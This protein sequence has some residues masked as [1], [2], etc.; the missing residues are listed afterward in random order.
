[1]FNPSIARTACGNE[2]LNGKGC[3]RIVPSTIC[4]KTPGSS[5][6][7]V[8]IMRKGQAP[9]GTYASVCS[10]TS[11]YTWGSKEFGQLKQCN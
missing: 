3:W 5:P 11:T 6:Y 4:S 8:E 1:M 10:L 9:K 7:S 2:C